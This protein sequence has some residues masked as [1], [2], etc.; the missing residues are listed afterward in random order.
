MH[1]RG[2]AAHAGMSSWQELASGGGGGRATRVGGVCRVSTALG[3]RA[4]AC[5]RAAGNKPLED[6]WTDVAAV[7]SPPSDA[8]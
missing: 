4:R 3:R 5:G 2:A 7:R 1:A 8:P 6:G